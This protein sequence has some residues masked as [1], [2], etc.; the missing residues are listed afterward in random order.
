MATFA[1]RA[2]LQLIENPHIMSDA[3][4][5][6]RR[7]SSRLAEKEDTMVNGVGHAYDVV[8]QSQKSTAVVK[9]GKNT[10]SKSANKRKPCK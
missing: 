10:A 7:T 2:P 6:G 3:Q 1:T 4:R 9:G 5:N 8:K